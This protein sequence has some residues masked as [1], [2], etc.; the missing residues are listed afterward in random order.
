MSDLSDLRAKLRDAQL[1]VVPYSHSDWAW[2]YTR[3]WH[4]ERYTLV[5]EDVLEI[6]RRDPDYKW[7]FD[8]ECEQLAPFRLRRPDLMDE[9]RVR[10]REG[11]IGIAGGTI[12]NP[13]PHRVGGETLI[14]NFVMGRR[15]FEREFPGCDLS[16]L[17]LN[18]VIFGHTQLPQIARKCGYTYYRG[19]RP[20]C[21]AA[22]G[23]PREFI[24]RSPDGTEMIC[25][26]GVY[27]GPLAQQDFMDKPWDEAAAELMDWICTNF[28]DDSPSHVLFLP[29]G[30][31]DIRPLRDPREKPL[32]TLGLV[33][34]WNEHEDAPM[35]FGTPLDYYQAVAA[36]KDRLPII[37]GPVDPVGWS[38][39][40]G[41]IGNESLRTWRRQCEEQ[42]LT[43]EKLS[44]AC[45][46]RLADDY[47]QQRFD[48]LWLDFLSCCPHA[49]LWLFAKDYDA[50]L[51]KLKSTTAEAKRIADDCAH[52]IMNQIDVDADN[53][54]CGI[55]VNPE[56]HERDTL[57]KLHKVCP[58]RG[59]RSLQVEDA[60]GAALPYQF[61]DAVAYEDGTLKEAD[62]LVRATVPAM[63]YT[64]VFMR[65][66]D[67]ARSTL[68]RASL[69][70]RAEGPE[71]N[72]LTC[73][74]PAADRAVGPHG[75]S[76]CC[77]EPLQCLDTTTVRLAFECDKLISLV[78]K[79]T[80]QEQLAPGDYAGNDVRL[81]VIED[82]GPYHFGP[83]IDV[84]KFE[85]A[86]AA[87]IEDGPLCKQA[88]FTGSIGPHG[89]EQRITVYE[90]TSRIDFDLTLECVGGDGFFRVGFPMAYDGDITVDVPFGVEP[91]DVIQE[92]Y[93]TCV[94]RKRENVFYGSHW[95]D[96]CAGGHGCALIIEPGQQGFCHF[97]EQRLLG[98]TFLKIIRHPQGG[99]ERFETRTREGK[100]RQHFRWA[101]YPHGGNW[102]AAAVD[103][104]ALEF[105]KPPRWY[106]KWAPGT[107]QA[108]SPRDSFLQCT[109]PNVALSSFYRE[110]DTVILR[111]HETR[112]QA[113]ERV[114]VALPFA[115]MSAAKTDCLLNPLDD[116]VAVDGQTLRFDVGPWEIATV[117][118]RL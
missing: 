71:R 40:Y 7:Y 26:W 32:D 21:I 118:L 6:M 4:E 43:A 11:R 48:Q 1:F 89:V 49:T 46:L 101:L 69:A 78:D 92:P 53:R 47:P 90:H 111:V 15:Y 91:R 72:A 58:K 96:Y 99:W 39:W 62:V 56:L 73:V 106:W 115:P 34:R 54:E 33:K 66:L 63:G 79:A 82:T 64:T 108:L 23:I 117:A 110:G 22:R 57:V 45:L 52:R 116:A 93:D 5:F 44:T 98:H 37:E 9:L 12:S 55:V 28:A 24:W 59:C 35:C 20:G 65:E 17:T 76:E 16:V 51:W 42:L 3:Q 25:S 13:H 95:A 107:G 8:T 102:A 30:A 81:H 97:P 113:A 61:V 109:A 83:V 77:N 75:L 27:G 41:Q 114:E 50:M 18:D 68:V 86:D 38:Y 103:K 29:R 36:R 94:E 104:E 87:V 60:H 2:T 19:T 14:R 10:V 112:G 70:D 100:G 80:G 84:L 105:R 67:A 74:L 85:C 88:R 31:D